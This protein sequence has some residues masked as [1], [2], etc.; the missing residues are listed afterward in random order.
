MAL[1][2][3]RVAPLLFCSGLCALIYQT[4]WLRELRLI[5]GFSTA[6]SAAVLAIFMGGLGLGGLLLGERAERSPR[7][8]QLY[9]RLELLISLAAAL[10]PLLIVLCRA[11]YFALGGTVGLGA[12]VGTALRLLL[13]TLVL[14]LPTLLM[15][16]TLPAAARAVQHSKD[17]RR[18]GLAV[19]YGVNTLGAVS[20]ALLSTF[21]L[22]E[23]LGTRKTLWAACLL[24]LIVAA[25]AALLARAG[26]PAED[27]AE[28]RAEEPAAAPSAALPAPRFVLLSAAV[29]GFAFLLMELVWYRM[30]G[31]ILG[32]SSFTFGLI[33]AVALLGIG[34]GGVAYALVGRERP[35]TLGGFALTCALE[36]LLVAVPFALG[37]WVAEVAMYLRPLAGLGFYGL[38]LGWTA[39]TLLVVFP[40]AFVSG[41]QF[42][43]LIGLLGRGGQGVGRQ[44]GQAYAFNTL[45]SILGSLAGGFGLLPLLSAPGTWRLCAALLAVQGVAA[46]V[47]VV[48]R[49][50]HGVAQR[51]D[52]AAALAPLA[53]LLALPLL[54]AEGPSAVWRHGGIG[55]GR[56]SPRPVANGV[57][58]WENAVRRKMLWERD[59]VESN[60]GVAGAEGLAFVV[61]GKVDGNC[62]GD[63]PTQ[64]F[65]GLLPALLHDNP[66]R[67]LVVGLGTGSTSGWLAAVPQ[68]ERVDT[69]EIEPA[70]LRLA[71]ECAAV[72]HDVLHNPRHSLRI[73]DAREVLLT[74]KERYDLIVSEPSNPYRAG[75]ASFFTQEFYRAA[76]QRLGQGGLFVQW[77]QAYDIDAQTA[78]TVY[79]TMLTVFPNIQTW[80]TTGGDLL[81]IAS[82]EPQVLAVDA[83]RARLRQEPYQGAA[84]DILRVTDLEGLLARFVASEALARELGAAESAGGA[85]INTDDRVP[86]E[87]GFARSIGRP[88]DFNVDGLRK[89]AQRRGQDLPALRG[90]LDLLR[91]RDLRVSLLTLV[92]QEPMQQRFTT[93]EQPRRARAYAAYRDGDLGLAL[94]AFR[95]APREP[96]DLFELTLLA[97]AMADA[98]EEAAA[99][100]IEK[101]R[102]FEPT[103]AAAL[104][105]RLHLRRGRIKEAG[106]ASEDALRRYRQDPWPTPA[107]MG[108]ALRTAVDVARRA[109]QG[110]DAALALRMYQLLRE[111]FVVR[112]VNEERLLALLEVARICDFPRLCAEA[113]AEQE[114]HV[115]WQRPVLEDRVECYSHGPAESDGR[116]AQARADLAW[117]VDHEPRPLDEGLVPRK[118]APEA[119]LTP[120]PPPAPFAPTAAPDGGVSDGGVRDG[121]ARDR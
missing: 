88:L 99:P 45:G 56:A 71:S 104:S 61:N 47:Y 70:I 81:L 116:L 53:L 20:G 114:P 111:P 57:R 80:F 84:R 32:G 11:V 15:G 31:P 105:A 59:G 14:A 19:L 5:F 85:A 97:E 69:V 110:G 43:L 6:A 93:P 77:M 16:G 65:L 51:P 76:A 46:V 73:A 44:V 18:G 62:R 4:A 87:Y 17:Q 98:G 29:V 60:V 35:A 23:A 121:G 113:L 82:R 79:A 95:A 91:L 103:E 50:T 21:L 10:T 109:A 66:R 86:V 26:G 58:L 1:P 30:L 28:E 9:A 34:L 119:P 90:D 107:L 102:A 120:R 118:A 83:L 40:A 25:V 63:A 106:A 55:V 96:A 54:L 117:Y 2:V 115:M 7:P 24:N 100:H 8:L 52:R 13:S 112:V 41:V 36:A 12:G 22:L 64:V 48:R 38:V 49:D 3:S 67:A 101:L 39:I 92:G 78:R 42:P 72:N 75:I 27:S 94:R 108:R 68:I 37:D 89:L 74:S 33:L